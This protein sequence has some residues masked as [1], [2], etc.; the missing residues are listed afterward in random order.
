MHGRVLLATL[1][2]ALLLAAPASADLP[3]R[4]PR[5]QP[6][7]RGRRGRARTASTQVAAAGLDGRAGRSPPSRTA[8]PR[9]RPPRTRTR[10]GGGAQLLR[11]RAGRRRQHGV[12]GR[13]TSA[14][15][16]PEIDQGGVTR[17][18]VGADRRLREPGRRGDGLRAAARR[19]GRGDRAADGLPAGDA[20]EREGI[21][22]PAAADGHG[23]DPAATRA[24]RVT[25]TATRTAGQYNDGYVDNVSFSSAAPPVAGQSVGRASRVAARCSCKRPGAQVR[26]ARRRGCSRTAPRSTRARAWS[27]SRAPTAASRSLLRRH[28]QAQPVGRDHD[29]DAEREARL[30][31]A[32]RRARA[33]RSPRRASCGATA[34]ASSAP[35]ASTARR[36]CAAPSG[37]S[38]TRAR[39]PGRGSRRAA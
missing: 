35:R 18:A 22:E 32:A 12:A 10:L 30:L 13:S 37:S 39:R 28:L 16:A 14:R 20:A 8:R 9:S 21:T 6:G 7:R 27:R 25:I 33:R 36:P 34:R 4:Q 31:Q 24:I 5:R 19:G 3:A 15:A 11:R 1:A 26:P 2:A 29:A 38:R 23:R 17:D